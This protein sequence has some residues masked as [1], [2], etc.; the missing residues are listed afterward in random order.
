[1]GWTNVGTWRATSDYC[2][3]GK[4]PVF[5]QTW[6]ATSLH[7]PVKQRYLPRRGTPYPRPAMGW[8]NVG[9]WRATSD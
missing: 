7:C 6:H 9:T 2:A 4:V 5:V 1:M 3:R 8:T